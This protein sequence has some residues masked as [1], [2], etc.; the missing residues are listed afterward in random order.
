MI[1]ITKVLTELWVA[2][3]CV[4]SSEID[5]ESAIRN[6]DIVLLFKIPT[7]ESTPAH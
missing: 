2:S 4:C 1:E 5:L 6:L 3:L 7:R